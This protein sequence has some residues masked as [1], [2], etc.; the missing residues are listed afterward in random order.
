M[1]WLSP[2]CVTAPNETI[3]FLLHRG[4]Y[5]F[6]LGGIPG[7]LRWSTGKGTALECAGLKR[8]EFLKT[9]LS[10]VLPDLAP[11]DLPLGFS[12]ESPARQARNTA[13]PELHV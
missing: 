4:A 5:S 11:F 13:R 12:Q 9:D 2:C 3:I 8:L 6:D 1:H 7:S 10:Q